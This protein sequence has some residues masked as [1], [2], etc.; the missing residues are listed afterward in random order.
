MYI[1]KQVKLFPPA[2]PIWIGILSSSSSQVT[3]ALPANWRP[4]P[5]GVGPASQRT[6]LQ[7]SQRPAVWDLPLHP[8]LPALLRG[9]EQ[10]A[11][12]GERLHPENLHV[13]STHSNHCLHKCWRPCQGQSH[14]I[15]QSIN[16]S[17]RFC[18][19]LVSGSEL[20]TSETRQHL[21]FFS[22]SAQLQHFSWFLA[23]PKCSSPNCHLSRS[24]IL[25]FGLGASIPMGL[26]TRRPTIFSSKAA[27]PPQT[28]HSAMRQPRAGSAGKIPKLFRAACA[29]GMLP[30]QTVNPLELKFDK[31]LNKAQAISQTTQAYWNYDKVVQVIFIFS[32]FIICCL[33]LPN[34]DSST[35]TPIQAACSTNRG[36][37]PLGVGWTPQRTRL[38]GGQWSAL[39]NL[40]RHPWLT[41]LLQRCNKTAMCAE[42]G[43]EVFLSK[44][45]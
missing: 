45:F 37:G 13:C 22:F 9:S 11:V 5:L 32:A 28:P 15:K 42:P 2:E 6:R 3:T 43:P 14:G 39:W 4:R 20:R 23:D 30:P 29:Q 18:W 36:A 35:K 44:N 12:L 40:P 1:S 38:Q 31:V 26:A 19:F 41:A 21:S 34:P 27:F 8:Q 10:P 7:G 24:R 33:E 17:K 16:A 25:T